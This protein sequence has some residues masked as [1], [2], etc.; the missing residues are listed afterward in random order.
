VK[1]LFV[2]PFPPSKDGIGKY[3]QTFMTAVRAAGHEARVIVPRVHPGHPDDVIGVLSAAGRMDL[4]A[5]RDTAVEWSADLIH[6]QF[7]VA[8]FGTRTRALLSWL[9]LVRATTSIPV[10]V[11]MHEVTRDTALLRSLG[12][13][14]YGKLSK[15]CDHVIVHTEAARA[16]LTG[17]VRMPAAAVSVI[18]HPDFEQPRV[19]SSPAQLREQF[20]LGD[21]ELLL[22]FGFIHVDKGLGDLITALS[23]L[24]RSG[25]PPLDGV[26]LVI[27]G[28]VRPRLSVF[29]VFE[30]RD[31]MHFARVLRRSRR[32]GL[33][34]I[35]VL[36]GYVPEDDVAGWFESAVGV[37]LP[38]RRT[39]QSGVA[40]LANSFGVP[41]L[42]SKVGGLAEQYA[43]S[44]WLFSPCNPQDLAGVLAR[45]I[46]TSPQHRALPGGTRA[47][48]E[49]ACVLDATLG[50]YRVAL[51]PRVSHPMTR[52]Y[53][54]PQ[55][56]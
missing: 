29:R 37:V 48:A 28:A 11:T 3:T 52:S 20:D 18:A 14:V 25:T 27:A 42:A 10:V 17:P 38:Y 47:T 46:A 5:L 7:A 1:I 51:Q 41:V 35:V 50:I 19:V 26:R 33:D 53:A 6:V 8:A 4:A 12:R 22:A 30:L 44:P 39:E 9:E 2:S 55:S 16:V 21:K 34:D 13:S 24:R 40:G 49:M 54:A 43:S 56:T 31:R 23:I 36:T 15:L 45:F 32:A